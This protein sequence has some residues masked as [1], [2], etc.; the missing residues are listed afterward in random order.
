ME[1]RDLHVAVDTKCVLSPSAESVNLL[2]KLNDVH[3][4]Q[5]E[6]SDGK[7]R[8]EDGK[9]A[10]VDSLA[11]TIAIAWTAFAEEASLKELYDQHDTKPDECD[12]PN[13]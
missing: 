13:S 5:G 6:K 9:N 3:N 11:T 4:C 2:V 12:D 8:L 1:I 7:S 10:G